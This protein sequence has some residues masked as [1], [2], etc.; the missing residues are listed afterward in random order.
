[1]LA[2]TGRKL[3]TVIG[4]VHVEIAMPRDAVRGVVDEGVHSLDEIRIVL[5]AVLMVAMPLVVGKYRTQTDRPPGLP[6]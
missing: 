3:M 1:M 5:P 6:A 4:S 2:D